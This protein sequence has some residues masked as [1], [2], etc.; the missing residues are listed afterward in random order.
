MGRDA[1]VFPEVLSVADALLDPAM[2]DLAWLD[3]GAGRPRALPADGMFCRRLGER[4]GREW[5][6]PLAATDHGDPLTSWMGSVIRLRRGAGG[7][8]RYDNDPLWVRQEHQS[9]S[10]AGQLRVLGKE[11]NAP[12][13]GRMWRATVPAEQ[14]TLITRAIESAEELGHQ[15]VRR[16]VRR[17]A[18][19]TGAE[20]PG[21]DMSPLFA[22]LQR[23]VDETGAFWEW[24]DAIPFST[25]R[26]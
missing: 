9:A 8:P 1:V 20:A 25:T 18:R 24:A 22:L 12:G 19:I 6:G 13:S 15:L 7:P 4:V 10:M 21:T 17:G 14:R 16:R 3:S 23:E 26:S 11:K 5:L 2:A